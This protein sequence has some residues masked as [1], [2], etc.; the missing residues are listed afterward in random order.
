MAIRET[1]RKAI[2]KQQIIIQ[3][4]TQLA[5]NSINGKTHVPRDIINLVEDMCTLSL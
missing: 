2:Q 1:I 3:S 5:V 4:D